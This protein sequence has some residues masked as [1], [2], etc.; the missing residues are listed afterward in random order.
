MRIVCPACSTEYDVPDERVSIGQVVRC[1]R[2]G[3]DWTPREPDPEMLARLAA[4]A[5]PVAAVPEPEPEPIKGPYAAPAM[6]PLQAPVVEP[7]PVRT[8]RGAGAG[9]RA[10]LVAAWVISLGIVGAGL[11]QGY[12]SRETIMRAWPP[13]VRAYAALGLAPRR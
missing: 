6:A 12:V 1:A 7:A 13:S 8:R 4:V 5:E 3:T 10:A 2:C 11:W 9:R